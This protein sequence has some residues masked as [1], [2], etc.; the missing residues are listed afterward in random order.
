MNELDEKSKLWHSRVYLIA[1][2]MADLYNLWESNGPKNGEK[3]SFVEKTSG[4][5]AF[6]SDFLTDE[7]TIKLPGY[8]I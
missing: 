3:L 1:R 6:L 7:N 5:I 8:E 4:A 2:D